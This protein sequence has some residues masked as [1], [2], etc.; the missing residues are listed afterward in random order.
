MFKIKKIEKN[1]KKKSPKKIKRTKQSGGLDDEIFTKKS[2]E[3]CNISI[4]NDITISGDEKVTL[5]GKEGIITGIVE[6][7]LE[8]IKD[9]NLKTDKYKDDNK[10]KNFLG[11][12]TH[13]NNTTE[14]NIEDFI[15][16]DFIDYILTVLNDENFLTFLKTNTTLKETE[17]ENIE[18]LQILKQEFQNEVAV[19]AEREG[20]S[21]TEAPPKGALPSESLIEEPPSESPAGALPAKGD[22]AAASVEEEEAAE[23]KKKE[24]LASTAVGVGVGV[25]E[26]AKTEKGTEG[27]RNSKKKKHNRRK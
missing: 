22:A 24:A 2:I 23:Q 13:I 20:E 27:G 4:E 25:G 7:L 6:L 19:A 17:D 1:N 26:G 14:N 9:E 11:L 15:H 8:K 21:L 10:F 18:K 16:Q 5:Y 3:Y 12:I